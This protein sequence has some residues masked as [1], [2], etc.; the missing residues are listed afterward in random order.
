ML[1]VRVLAGVVGEF[2]SSELTLC[3][4]SQL[5][6]VPPH[7]TAVARKRPRLFCQKWQVAGYTWT[8]IHPW[9]NKVHVGWLC[10]R[11]IVWEPSREKSSH[12]TCQGTLGHNHPSFLPKFSQA[13]KKPPHS[14][15]SHLRVIWY[16]FAL[17]ESILITLFGNTCLEGIVFVCLLNWSH[18]LMFSPGVRGQ[19][20]D[21][22]NP[23]GTSS[24]TKA[25]PSSLFNVL[26][27]ADNL[28]SSAAV[29]APQLFNPS[30]GKTLWSD[31]F[32]P[33]PKLF[34]PASSA[35]CLFSSFLNTSAL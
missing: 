6:S 25:V 1:Q 9:P 13:R 31:S 3:V 15:E 14:H 10:C 26:P 24:S 32:L 20:V 2:S 35:C 21:V 16:R 30:G 27:G 19:Y 4:D 7:V 8:C 17:T 23:G 22:L 5:V 29:S 28:N 11:S 12:A 34:L 33:L 18:C